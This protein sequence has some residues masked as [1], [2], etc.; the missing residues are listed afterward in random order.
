MKPKYISLRAV[1]DALA[2]KIVSEKYRAL[3]KSCWSGPHSN[4]EVHN[5]V[6]EA[7]SLGIALRS[8]GGSK[9]ATSS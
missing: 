7:M 6:S 5:K 4:M 2:V 1:K 9:Y 8:A 3:L